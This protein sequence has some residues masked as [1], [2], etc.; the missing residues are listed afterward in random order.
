MKVTSSLR[1]LSLIGFLLLIA[2]FYEQCEKRAVEVAEEILIDTTAV[3]TVT[4]NKKELI[5]FNKKAQDSINEIEN[6]EKSHIQK[7]YEF[8]DDENSKNAFEMASITIVILKTPQKEFRESIDKGVLFELIKSISFI[9]IVLISTSCVFL[10]FSKKTKLLYI[11]SLYNLFF[12]FISIL[13]VVFFDIFFD[14]IRQIKWGYYAFTL[15]QLCVLYV[16]K[17]FELNKK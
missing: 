7:A 11:L 12:I 1:I 5:P 13:C 3:E 10:S 16:S 14:H 6:I 4:F 15:V 9:L 17:N 8:I 2:P